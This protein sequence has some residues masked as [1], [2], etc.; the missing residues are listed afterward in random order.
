MYIQM[1]FNAHTY[2]QGANLI[3]SSLLSVF[4]RRR[5]QENSGTEELIGSTQA[6]THLTLVHSSAIFAQVAFTFV[7]RL[8]A[9]PNDGDDGSQAIARWHR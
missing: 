2:C 7:S 6:P 4:V 3:I 9:V 8:L 1:L 5:V